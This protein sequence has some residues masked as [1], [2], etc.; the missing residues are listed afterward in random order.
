MFSARSSSLI[1]SKSLIMNKHRQ[2]HVNFRHFVLFFDYTFLSSFLPFY[3]NLF[4]YTKTSATENIIRLFLEPLRLQKIFK[5]RLNSCLLCKRYL[6]KTK[7]LFINAKYNNEPC[8]WGRRLL[9]IQNI[10]SSGAQV[11]K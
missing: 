8:T 7:S 10:L 3:L 2:G 11:K 6:S 5:S 4:L 9:R 1:H